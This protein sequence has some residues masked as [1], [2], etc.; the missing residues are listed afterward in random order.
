MN[1]KPAKPPLQTTGKRRK[2]LLNGNTSR[3]DLSN[4]RKPVDTS[5]SNLYQVCELLEDGT[6]EVKSIL[7]YECNVIYECRICL[8]L[9]RSI[10]NLV[11]HKREYC[12]DEFDVRLH[13][14]V[15][16]N[17]NAHPTRE[18]IAHMYKTEQAS[19][20]G[21]NNDGVNNDGVINDSVNDD[22]VKN[23]RILRSQVSK[24]SN[25]KDL[26]AILDMLNKEREDHIE[27]QNLENESAI[28]NVPDD[29]HIYLEP[30]DTNCPAVYQPIESPDAV[31]EAIDL[32][33]EQITKLQNITDQNALVVEEPENQLEKSDS[34]IQAEMSEEN[35]E[36]SEEENEEG[37]EEENEERNKEANEEGIEEE[38]EERNE[39]ESDEENDEENKA[40]I[41]RLPMNN[42][43]CPICSA[44]FSTK[45][46]LIVHIK[47]LH[48][49]KR[50]CYPCP[51]CKNTFANTWSTYRHLYRV[52]KMTNEQ[53]RKLKSEVQRK[54]FHRKTT[55]TK[56]KKN[57]HAAK[58]SALKNVMENSDKTQEL[59]NVESG[60]K[61]RGR[62]GRRTSRKTTSSTFSQYCQTPIATCD[63]K[64][65]RIKHCS[66]LSASTF[67]IP[68]KTE[69]NLVANTIIKSSVDEDTSSKSSERTSSSL[70]ISDH[71]MPI[72]I[73]NVTNTSKEYWD[74][75]GNQ[76]NLPERNSA[77]NNNVSGI[78]LPENI[79]ATKL[80][81]PVENQDNCMLDEDLH[82]PGATRT[83]AN[84]DSSAASKMRNKKEE[85]LSHHN[86]DR[87]T[88]PGE[89]GKIVGEDNSESQSS[90]IQP[91]EKNRTLLMESKIA[92]I[93]DYR[94]Q[95]CLKCNRKFTSTPNLRRHMAMHVGWYRYRCKLCDFKCFEKCD[96]VT[97][98]KKMHNMQNNRVA[99]AEMILGISHDDTCDE[100]IVADTTDPKTKSDNPDIA[101]D[102]TASSDC[103]PETRVNFN[104]SSDLDA[105]IVSQSETVANERVPQSRESECENVYAGDSDKTM[106][107]LLEYMEK[108]KN[109]KDPIFT[110]MI[111]QV[112]YGND[113]DAIKVQANSD[114]PVL[115]TNDGENERLNT[116]DNVN[117]TS[118]IKSEE[119]F[120]PILNNVKHQRPMRNRIKS[121]N[122][123]FGSN[124]TGAIEVQAE[125]DKPVL[126]TNDRES[127]R[128][129]TNDN[130][131]DASLIES[132]GTFCPILNNVKH[133]RPMRNRIKPLNEDFIYNLK[134]MTC[135]RESA[136]INDSE[137]LHIRKKAKF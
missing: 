131:N 57:N 74:M 49:S 40:L 48:T 70:E 50:L 118:P 35:D 109:K 66:T 93:A 115:E 65:I 68:C 11:S 78:A 88:D 100:D 1:P 136:L 30:I 73:K 108:N 99:I 91:N 26:T 16:N 75:L 130:V 96:C 19:S 17:Y 34:P 135:R 102:V 121:L 82:S 10:V 120:C 20:D 6:D 56:N 137:T 132:T 90:L 15:L 32:V 25:K 28:S 107:E 2:R 95:R 67:V 59:I 60:T 4:L 27:K 98:C 128:V 86:E 114:K 51:C 24:K 7:S 13:K 44:K 5:V 76:H 31:V 55:M 42:L 12:V 79:D 111:R 105:R 61:L 47:T 46:T 116:N 37:I 117:D 22:G 64:T 126:E 71:E 43:S 63:E 14:R 39:E 8:A 29:Q 80:L 112:I 21:V 106:Q 52:H 58:V 72:R 101:M 85:A 119:A 89:G 134:E 103:Q 54:A 127:G 113:K 122:E 133:K 83:D 36:E 84:K 94:K 69:K 92:T 18:S 110:R 45:K 53:V 62:R 123:D 3:P 23:D 97:H 38:N 104:D 81:L 9:F 41:Y 33:K 129:N 124:N 77:D 87:L 125:P